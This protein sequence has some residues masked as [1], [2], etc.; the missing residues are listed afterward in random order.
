[1]TDSED[2]RWRR[3]EEIF[4]RVVERPEERDRILDQECADDSELRRELEELLAADARGEDYLDRPGPLAELWQAARALPERIGPFEV[5]GVLGRGGMGVVYLGEDA[6]LGRKVAIKT[7]SPE[8]R[9]NPVDAERLNREA[10]MLAALDHPN[11]AGIHGLERSDGHDYLVLEYI[12]GESLADR[13]ARGPLG[14]LET[15]RVMRQIAAGLEAAHR[16]GVVHR[17]LKPANVRLTPEGQA[18]VVDFGIAKSTSAE[19]DGLTAQGM[20]IGTAG[21]MSPEQAEDRAVDARSDVWAFGCMLWECLTGRRLF[22]GENRL[23]VLH[24]VVHQSPDW[25]LLP[26]LPPRLDWL[27]RRCLRKNIDERLR[28]LGD[29][30]L[31]LDEMLGELSDGGTGA[32]TGPIFRPAR[33][34]LS[35]LVKLPVMVV[36]ALTLLGVGYWAGRG[37]FERSAR[38]PLHLA[39]PVVS[40]HSEDRLGLA[41]SPSGDVLAYSGGPGVRVR[42]LST[43]EDELWVPAGRQ[44]FFSPDG[45]W[46]GAFSADGLVKMPVGGGS[47]M[48]ITRLPGKAVGASW[49]DDDH[50]VYAPHWESE[51]WRVSADGGEGRPLTRLDVERGELSH[52]FPFVLPGSRGVLYTVKRKQIL[53]FDEAEIGV[54]DLRTG[55]QRVLIERAVS[56]GYCRGRLIFQ[57]E[58]RLLA[59]DL[60]LETLEL[61]GHPEMIVEGVWLNADVGTSYWGCSERGD[62]AYLQNLPPAEPVEVYWRETDGPRGASIELGAERINRVRLS[63]NGQQIVFGVTGANNS[64]WLHDLERGTSDRLVWG[65]GNAQFPLFAP[66]DRGVTFAVFGPEESGLFEIP[67]RGGN[68][69]TIVQSEPLEPLSWSPDGQRLL[70]EKQVGAKSELWVVT[71]EGSPRI[72]TETP[73]SEGDARFSPTDEL[74]VYTSDETGR[75]EIYLRPFDDG[76]G[77]KV[78]VS[79]DGGDNPFWSSDGRQIFFHHRGTLWRARLAA[80]DEI[81]LSPPERVFELEPDEVLIQL[82]RGRLLAVRSPKRTAP[83]P[84]FVRLLTAGR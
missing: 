61:G 63:P 16:R 31:E 43:D 4:E 7:L 10:R 20:L 19:A 15:L 44:P 6:Q 25:S 1:M 64:V 18:K 81:R 45:R 65:S 5:Q 50:I 52:R 28:N 30:A 37:S 66:G 56:P 48:V 54:V 77:I 59:I 8:L 84:G 46:I 14:L 68:P 71:R 47:P 35:G 12:P 34:S 57:R 55:E 3:L 58:G 79:V 51:L 74:V 80:E 11:L 27:L 36:V 21:Y 83:M 60:D 24:A 70:A 73:F 76:A 42:L 26:E 13:L 2:R 69:Q 75:R 29:A 38:S 62:L 17:D 9:G 23:A 78:R 53:S 39:V 72:W 82:F 33:P 49:G 67:R 41:L 22:T 40:F 32:R